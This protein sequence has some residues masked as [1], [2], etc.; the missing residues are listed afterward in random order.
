ME[1]TVN[2]MI[3]FTEIFAGCLFATAAIAFRARLEKVR[4]SGVRT[5]VSRHTS[6]SLL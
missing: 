5:K 4:S 3:V 6:R 2:H 1:E